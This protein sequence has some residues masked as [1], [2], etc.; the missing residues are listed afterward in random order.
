MQPLNNYP[1]GVGP[2]TALAFTST[3]DIPARFNKSKAVR[4]VLGLMPALNESGEVAAWG[5]SRYAGTA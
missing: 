5:A 3:I 4:P 1:P 2:I